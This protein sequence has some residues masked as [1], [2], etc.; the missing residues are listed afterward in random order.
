M[1]HH[2]NSESQKSPANPELT[3]QDDGSE[4]KWKNV[5]CFQ[6]KQMKPVFPAFPTLA[7]ECS[8]TVDFRHLTAEVPTLQNMEVVH[9]HQAVSGNDFY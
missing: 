3:I 4:V 1:G 2:L 5:L 7:L 6:E 8:V 9:R